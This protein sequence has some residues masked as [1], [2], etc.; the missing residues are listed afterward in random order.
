M[1]TW[2]FGS[3]FAYRLPLC[4]RSGKILDFLFVNLFPFEL[5]SS[6]VAAAIVAANCNTASALNMTNVCA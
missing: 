4:E 5:L 2:W 1:L 3:R 6:H